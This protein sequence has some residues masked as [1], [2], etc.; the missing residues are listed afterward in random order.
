M[1]SIWILH[2]C[3]PSAWYMATAC[4][5]ALSLSMSWK[6][7]VWI[8]WNSESKTLAPC[9]ACCGWSIMTK[10]VIIINDLFYYNRSVIA[11]LTLCCCCVSHSIVSDSLWAHVPQPSRLPCP[12]DSPS[13]N[14]GM[15]SHSLLRRICPTQ[16]SNPGL[17]I[18]QADSLPSEPPGKPINAIDNDINNHRIQRR[19]YTWLTLGLGEQNFS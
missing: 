11:M 5:Y 14:T 1:G 15:G 18:L 7:G 4:L 16:G 6:A 8:K 3:L 10:N 2:L 9:L 12:W 17:P 19:K 13:R